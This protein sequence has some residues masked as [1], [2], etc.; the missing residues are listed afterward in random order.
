MLA[1]FRS[2]WVVLALLGRIL[3]PSCRK[4]APRWTKMAPRW[5]KIAPRW[6]KIAPRW[7]KI[8]QH[9]LQEES[10]DPKNLHKCCTLVFFLVF[11]IFGKIAPK[12]QNKSPRCSQKCAKLA[13]LGSKLAILGTSWRQVGQLSAILAPTWPILAPRWAARGTFC[14]HVSEIFRGLAPNPQKAT[15]N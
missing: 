4:M 3:W 15:Q 5:P 13:I 7:P 10:Q 1:A 2:F 11:V 12:M 14:T 8:A 6:S 9:S